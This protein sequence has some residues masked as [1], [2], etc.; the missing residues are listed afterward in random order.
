MLTHEANYKGVRGTLFRM[1]LLS[2]DKI[3]FIDS[4]SLIVIHK[5]KI[6]ELA[7]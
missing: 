2:G 5:K 3:F 4:L 7:A 1:Y 6:M